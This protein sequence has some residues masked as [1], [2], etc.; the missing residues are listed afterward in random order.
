MLTKQ[1]TLVMAL[2]LG[3]VLATGA[4]AQTKLHPDLTSE[5]F[6]LEEGVGREFAVEVPEDGSHLKFLLESNRKLQDNVDLYVRFAEPFDPNVNI[7]EQALYYA[8]GETGFEHLEITYASS[9]PLSPGTWYALVIN[10][11]EETARGIE[12]TAA[13]QHQEE[14]SLEPLKLDIVYT[15][16]N[17]EGFNNGSA[18]TGQGGNNA[19]TLGDARKAALEKAV[20]MVQES[21]T[22]P[23]AVTVEAFF[24]PEMAS[25]D[26]DGGGALAS[27]G[28]TRVFRDFP[29]ARAPDTWYSG[30]IVPRL[31]GTDN[32]RISN[33]DCRAGVEADVV[34]RF[35]PEADWWYGFDRD[36]GANG[37]DFIAVAVHE[38]LHGLGFLSFADVE[39]GTLFCGRQGD[40]F[41]REG[42]AGQRR[43]DAYLS[44]LVYQTNGNFRP[45]DQLNDARRLEAFTSQSD[46]LWDGEY[47]KEFWGMD[48][49]GPGQRPPLHAPSEPDP[50]SSVSHVSFPDIMFFRGDAP[51]RRDDI[52]IREGG[53]ELGAA[54]YLLRDAGWDEDPKEK[55]TGPPQPDVPRGMWFDRAR[56]GHG[57]DFQRSGDNW[58][59]VFFTYDDDGNPEWFLAVGQIEEG[60]FESNEDGLQR[61]TYDATDNLP[62]TGQTVGSVELD[63]NATA[64]SAACDDGFDRNGAVALARFS[65][66]INGQSGDWCAEP[67]VFGPNAPDPDFSGHWFAGLDDQG[68]GMTIQ[69]RADGE[70]EILVNTLYYYDGEGNPRWAQG[71]TTDFLNRHN[72]QA[73]D[74]L[75]FEGYARDTDCTPGGCDLG[76]NPGTSA[77]PL[78]LRLKEPLQGAEPGSRATLDV[79]YLGPEG[80]G[81]PR[82]FVPIELLSDPS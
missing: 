18:F 14:P 19:P 26:D 37:F 23:V 24:D 82:N 8:I 3:A 36:F 41:C 35:N 11:G 77:G 39:S 15:D 76:T 73:I 12:L 52:N 48:F 29:G 54:W 58:F 69:V 71:V 22:S 44:Q 80:G 46:L 16:G 30:S 47:G 74:M 4:H 38:M 28:P 68:W 57:F 62:Q 55:L 1:P 27:A 43:T 79:D 59:L 65:W 20:E 34:I 5:P 45:V 32:C 81:W 31:T 13:L 10:A 40:P 75:Q 17:N 7:F 25:D 9:P 56:N 21:F 50:G 72:E 63:L 64:S 53:E 78:R 60:V 67:L 70:T 33:L 61:F 51:T 42:N 6:E 2:L 66:E 49:I